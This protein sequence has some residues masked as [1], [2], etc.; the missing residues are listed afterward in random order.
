MTLRLLIHVVQ[1]DAEIRIGDVLVDL[2]AP[3]LHSSLEVLRKQR[4][5]RVNVGL[6][7]GVRIHRVLPVQLEL[8]S[9]QQP[10]HDTGVDGV[11]LCLSR[12]GRDATDVTGLVHHL[13][14]QPHGVGHPHPGRVHFR[15]DVSR[16]A[17]DA[18]LLAVLRVR[19][20]RHEA[21]VRD[22]AV[23]PDVAVNAC[24]SAQ[25]RVRRFALHHDLL[26]VLV[27]HGIARGGPL[28]RR[29]VQLAEP[30][31]RRELGVVPILRHHRHGQERQSQHVERHD[32]A[33]QREHVGK[34]SG[35]PA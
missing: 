26:A 29:G 34:G 16:I 28:D 8:G 27:H 22:R 20:A 17:F 25:R 6:V 21:D 1:Q 2:A 23:G 19:Q 35:P 18:E 3:A 31:E 5:D 10:A 33:V 12:F 13:E 9:L 14:E 32:R 11:F 7:L 24:R 30:F 15:M 4:D